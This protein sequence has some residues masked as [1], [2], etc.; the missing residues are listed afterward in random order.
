[1]GYYHRRV[2]PGI[3]FAS[4]PHCFIWVQ[5]M[6]KSS[7]QYSQPFPHHQVSAGRLPTYYSSIETLCCLNTRRRE[8]NFI[9]KAWATYMPPYS[10][11]ASGQ[12]IRFTFIFHIFF[13]PNFLA[14]TVKS[15]H[16]MIS[17]TIKTDQAWWLSPV[18]HEASVAL[19]VLK[20]CKCEL[21]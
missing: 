6:P 12:E 17:F 20:I 15:C 8:R 7:T 11:P 19:E 2:T 21:I 5:T 9:L 4:T 14:Y 16:V 3:K 18:W 1:M 13:W 10:R